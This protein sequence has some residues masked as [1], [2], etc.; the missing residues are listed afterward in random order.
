[1]IISSIL[2]L[3]LTGLAL[4]QNSCESNRLNAVK[5]GQA[6]PQG[7][8]LGSWL[9]LEGW[10]VP[11]LWDDNGCNKDAN[12]GNYLLEKCLGDRAQSVMEG[13]WSSWVTE[14][15]FAELSR[16]GVNLVRIPVGWW[17]VS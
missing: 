5:N 15:D 6:I 2:V 8:N 10:I 4:G 12:P 1:M 16:R 14:N 9:I 7:V 17:H 11:H 3:C 13:H